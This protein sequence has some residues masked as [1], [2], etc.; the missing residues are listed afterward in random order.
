[1][2]EDKQHIGY[3]F[4]V[5]ESYRVGGKSISYDGGPGRNSTRFGLVAF[6]A[7][8]ASR[9]GAH[10]IMT[11]I[12][13]EAGTVYSKNTDREPVWEFPDDPLAEGWKVFD[14]FEVYE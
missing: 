6:P 4:A 13:S 2:S 3:Y 10:G 5:L 1:M 14:R 9:D 11:F 7:P 8:G 12:V